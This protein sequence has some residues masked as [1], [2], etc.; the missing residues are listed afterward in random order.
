MNYFANMHPAVIVTYFVTCMMMVIVFF[1]PVILAICFLSQ[2][3]FLLYCKGICKGSK[4]IVGCMSLWVVCAGVNMLVNHRGVT[5]F[6]TIVGLP[7]TLEC[8]VYGFLT[9]VFLAA[10]LMLFSCYNTILTSEKLMCLFGNTLPQF[11]L[12]FSMILR[13]VPKVKR[14]YRKIRE[15]QKLQTGILSALVG[16]ALEDSL[17]TGVVMRY[18]GYGMSKKR[19]SIYQRDMKRMDWGIIGLLI[20]G[21][22][23]SVILYVSSGTRIEFFPYV[24]Y[25]IDR[26]GVVSYGIYFCLAHVPMIINGMEEIKWRRIVSKI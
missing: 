19:T 25:V 8:L 2:G 1:D 26:R 3:I 10:S 23:V 17:E 7:I 9:G 5:V 16:I 12:V 24:E 4:F 18:R 20:I 21:T 15:N 22:A 14:D 6:A 11:S 13:L